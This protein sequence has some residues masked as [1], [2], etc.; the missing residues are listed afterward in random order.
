MAEEFRA[1]RSVNKEKEEEETR[2][3]ENASAWDKIKGQYPVIEFSPYHH[4]VS[5]W[6]FWPTTGKFK[7]TKTG[8]KGYSLGAFLKKI[9]GLK[10]RGQGRGEFKPF[11]R[12]GILWEKW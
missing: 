8:E 4:R 10:L 1:L 6:D 3:Q 12:T 11:K 7:H 5:G 9:E 2:K